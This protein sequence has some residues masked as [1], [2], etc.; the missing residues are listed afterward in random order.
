MTPLIILGVGALIAAGMGLWALVARSG[1][2]DG[3][4]LGTISSQWIN[5]QR[6]HERESS[7][8]R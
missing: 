7:S 6:A 1:H 2:Q 8:D 4:D 5:E 3:K